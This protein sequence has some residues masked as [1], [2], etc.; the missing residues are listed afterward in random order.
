MKHNLLSKLRLG[1]GIILFIY[2][3]THLVNHACGLV[4][5]DT[6]S[7]GRELFVIAWRSWP[8]TILLY[9]SLLVHISIFLYRLNLLQTF[10]LKP[11]EYF[12]ICTGL[13][14]PFLL[15][16]H[17]LGTRGLNVAFQ[18][19]DNYL[20][21][22]LVLWVY[23]PEKGL[24]QMILIAV[25]WLHG[26]M[27]MHFWL[28]LKRYYIYFAPFGLFLAIIIPAIGI[29]GFI[30]SGQEIDILRNNPIWMEN[31]NQSINWP[32]QLA[33]DWVNNWKII[34]WEVFGGLL[35]LMIIANRVRWFINSRKQK[36]YLTYVDGPVLK[37]KSGLTVLEASKIAKIRH[38]NL[39][40]G[41]GRC[42]TCRI[43][44][45]EGLESVEAPSSLEQKTLK[46]LHA[47]SNVRLACQLKLTSNLEVQLLVSPDCKPK[48]LNRLNI[49][50][51]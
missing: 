6:L 25:A 29:A 38:A 28:R 4:S 2:I 49:V 5:L 20:Y 37:V 47:P 1:S 13:A 26:C 35:V 8:G 9:G 34:F 30:S 16:E 32:N 44:L 42:A 48:D 40:G 12:Q 23:A 51:E 10:L 43:R 50:R 27:G 31:T 18:V 41:K 36:I 17:I 3:G 7:S 21:E 15:V 19:N 22:I 14:V 33:V 11:S 46:R 24:L 45:G 39:C